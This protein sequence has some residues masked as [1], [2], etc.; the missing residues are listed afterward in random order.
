M[1]KTW[2]FTDTQNNIIWETSVEEYAEEFKE[3]LNKEKRD[4]V[5]I[6]QG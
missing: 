1:K 5:I 2:K 4:Y 6:I 3:L